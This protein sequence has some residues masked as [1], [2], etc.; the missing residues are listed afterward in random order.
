MTFWAVWMPTLQRKCLGKLFEVHYSPLELFWWS[1][2][3]QSLCCQLAPGSYFFKMERS[4]LKERCKNYDQ[5]VLRRNLQNNRPHSTRRGRKFV[6]KRILSPRKISTRSLLK[7]WLKQ[8]RKHQELFKQMSTEA[9]FK[10]LPTLPCSLSLLVSYSSRCQIYSRRFGYP[11]GPVATP[12]RLLLRWIQALRSLLSLPSSG[13]YQLL[14]LTLL[15]HHHSVLRLQ[16]SS[17]SLQLLKMFFRTWRCYWW[18]RWWDVSFGYRS[19]CLGIW[20]ACE[21]D[22]SSSRKCSWLWRDQRQGG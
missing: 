17:T 4:K 13:L 19:Q 1:L 12:I 5:E 20:W 8:R 2:I 3:K 10:L 15:G 14:Q 7:S 21:R 9:I 18:L 22:G 16:A 11:S 6:K